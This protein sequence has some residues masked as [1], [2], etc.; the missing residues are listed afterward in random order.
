MRRGILSASA[1]AAF[2]GVLLLLAALP[3]V[4]QSSDNQCSEPGC[5]AKACLPNCGITSGAPQSCPYQ[6]FGN[7]LKNPRQVLPGKDGVLHLEFVTRVVEPAC[8]PT[9][10]LQAFACA[11][12]NCPGGCQCTPPATYDP[13]TNTCSDKSGPTCSA[14]NQWTMLRFP[15]RMYGTSIDPSRP[16]DPDNADDSNTIYGFPGPTMRVRKSSAPGKT[17]GTRLKLK[18]YNRLPSQ[19]YPGDP[20]ACNPACVVEP[21]APNGGADPQK[22]PNGQLVCQVPPDCYHGDN[23]TNLHFH[24]THVSPQEHSDFIL[25]SLLPKG[26]ENTK[27]HMHPHGDT[28]VGDYWY[29]INPIPWNQAE[30]THWYHPH[31]HGSTA[32][33]ILNGMAGALIIEG[34]FDDWL[35]KYY[36]VPGGG[37]GDFEKVLVL[38][39]VWPTINFYNT[40]HL[41]IYPPVLLVNG[42]ASPVIRMKP[43]ET[44]RWRFINATMQNGAQMELD[45]GQGMVWRQIAQDGVQLAEMNFICQPLYANTV[46][47]SST[48]AAAAQAACAKLYPPNV[49]KVL[50]GIPFSPGNRADFLVRAPVV[51]GTYQVMHQI[52]GDLNQ[53]VR[54]RLDDRAEALRAGAGLAKEVQ[55]N[56]MASVAEASGGTVNFKGVAAPLFSV[57]VEGAPVKPRPFPLTTLD[58]KNCATTPKPFYCWPETPVFLRDIDPASVI[59]R[60]VVAFSMEGTAPGL[61]PN[62][63]T[64]NGDGYCPNCAGET[65]VLGSTEQ[66]TV[67]NDSAP[68]HPFHIHINPF[69]LTGYSDPTAKAGQADQPNVSFPKP[70]IWWDTVALPAPVGNYDASAKNCTAQKPCMQFLTKFED[71]TGEYVIHCHFLGHEDRGMMENVQVV[72][73]NRQTEFGHP[74]AGR[75]DDCVT[76]PFQDAACDCQDPVCLQSQCTNAAMGHGG[77]H[78]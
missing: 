9:Y 44:Q 3:A 68:K 19:N 36:E 30:G 39:Q 14:G 7:D 54:S 29:D 69:Q 67:T 15:L 66:W 51:P 46:A 75:E 53:R 49:A 58:D 38:Q 33:Q 60:P 4:A 52:V 32:E 65:M 41:A 27:A 40:N 23:V 72:C 56:L 77:G 8:V 76:G 42:Q 21:P 55:H 17:D 25:L 11:P 61:Q 13:T 20:M 37:Q 74:V 2:L 10:G 24:G 59:D 62:Q 63:F 43:G 12:G 35:N 5:N 47:A 1:V 57:V 48:I 70:W 26:A 78:H 6:V 34:P 45:L 18:L 71:F 73:K 31:K 28:V 64:I 16:I 22:Y 50:Q